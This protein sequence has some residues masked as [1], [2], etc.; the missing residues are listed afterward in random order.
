MKRFL[1]TTITALFAVGAT[2]AQAD[3]RVSDRDKRSGAKISISIGKNHQSNRGFV[4]TSYVSK[5]PIKARSK[6]IKK[7]SFNTR[8]RARILLVEEVVKTRR[9]PRF[10][11]TVEARGKERHYVSKRR[12]KRIA[13]YNCSPRAR[14]KIHA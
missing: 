7:K 8:H 9:G 14:V 13:N 5:K 4:N 12:L 11:C 10:L 1:L 6:V 2:A 3:S